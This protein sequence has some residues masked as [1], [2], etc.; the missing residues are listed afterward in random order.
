MGFLLPFFLTLVPGGLSMFART[1][2]MMPYF[3]FED[4]FLLLLPIKFL[5]IL[6]CVKLGAFLAGLLCVLDMCLAMF[7]SP[8]SFLLHCEHCVVACF[9]ATCLLTGLGSWSRICIFCM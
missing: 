6:S 1:S 8:S 5:V 9:F 4:L 7:S 2:K 3:L